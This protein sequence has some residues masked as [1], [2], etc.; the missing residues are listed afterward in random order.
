MIEAKNLVL[1]VDQVGKRVVATE[2]S[3]K[4]R[5]SNGVGWCDPIGAHYTRWRD[6]STA[7]RVQ[8]MLE[9]AIDLA[10]DGFDLKTILG[11]LSKV[12]EFKA[13]G[14]QSYPMCRALTWALV[15]TRLEPNT[16]D[17][18]DLLKTYG[19]DHG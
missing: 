5:E 8:L 6:M 19:G 9:T 11:E 10:T 15:G 14:R 4:R 13:L 18:D 7:Q 3:N 2:R 16:M 17:F 12:D 1:W